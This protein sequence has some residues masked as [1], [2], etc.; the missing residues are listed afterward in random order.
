MELSL[1]CVF[2]LF[3][4]YFT[5]RQD[6]TSIRRQT[7]IIDSK[8]CRR[9]I[10]D[11]N[12]MLKQSLRDRQRQFSIKFRGMIRKCTRNLIIYSFNT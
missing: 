8:K 3:A 7:S 5:P 6:S 11:L 4:I 12:D 9:K 1:T 10:K 2:P